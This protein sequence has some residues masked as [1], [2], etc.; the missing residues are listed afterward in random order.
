[1]SV[2]AREVI[3]IP[4]TKGNHI[5][6]TI[7]KKLRVA[8]YSRVSTDSDDQLSSFHAQKAYYSD[9]ILKNPKWTAAGNFADEGISGATAEKR[10]DFMRMIRQCKKGKID[11]I[12]TKSVS[13]FARN[14][15]DAVQYVRQLKSMGVGVL[16]EKEGINTME[17]SSELFLTIMFSL[18]QEELFSLSGNVKMGIRMQMKEGKV[19]Y[20][21]SK[22]YGYKKGD[23]NKPEVI[24]EEALLIERMYQ[25]YL[26]G[27]SVNK[28]A[29]TLNNEGCTARKCD[30]WTTTKVR[31]IIEH[32]RYCGDVI[33]QKTFV[34]DPIS[35][36]TKVNNGELPKYHIKNN[37]QAIVTRE[38]WNLVQAEVIR[39]SNKQKTSEKAI[40]GRGKY[41]GKLAL[42]EILVCGCCGSPYSRKSWVK[43][44]KEK[45]YVWGCKAHSHDKTC[46]DSMNIDEKSLHDG[47]VEA[48][49]PKETQNNI[50]Q[51]P[52]LQK[53]QQAM[54]N[55]M[56]TQ[57]DIAEAEEKIE[58]LKQQAIQMVSECAANNSLHLNQEQI[59]ALSDEAKI[60][61]NKVDE[62]KSKEQEPEI[63]KAVEE[64]M[65]MVTKHLASYTD[66]YPREYDDD[67]VRQAIQYIKI[68]DSGCIQI[69]FNNGTSVMQQIVAKI[70]KK[71][72]V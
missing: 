13:R 47:I 35:K 23:D 1:M 69:V 39:R 49:F 24:P 56:N 48:L 62:A 57:F 29:E 27:D 34:E 58:R 41:N 52:L 70:R 2:Q 11:L 19:T 31:A 59:K 38:T 64:K 6:S 51:F 4:A 32:E 55:E 44:N 5:D 67:L 63:Q 16:F 3:V 8:S 60:L 66:G 42:S 36:K 12:I 40:S 33:L 20:Q 68:I 45:Q 25:R 65:Q 21:Y 30:K 72:A 61:Q 14:T 9:L 10:P 28:I 54:E 50:L 37:H 46:P 15:V 71:V 7:Q 43:R 22:M 17:E 26:L 18:A 53:I